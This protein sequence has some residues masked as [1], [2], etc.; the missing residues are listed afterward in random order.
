MPVTRIFD[1]DTWSRVW[2]RRLCVQCVGIDGGGG[3]Y[4]GGGDT[5]RTARVTTEVATCS[6]QRNCS[7][8]GWLVTGEEE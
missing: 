1:T 2:E 7:A 5:L 6:R 3:V 4:N 8:G